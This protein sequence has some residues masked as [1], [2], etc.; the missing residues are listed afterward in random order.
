MSAGSRYEVLERIAVG[1]FASV[2]RARDRELGREV[3]IKQI[4]P[5]FLHDER[6]LARYWQE[7]QLLAGLQHPNI[8]TI[9][10]IVRS[11]GW[12]IVELM[13]G[14]LEQHTHGEPIDLE[15]LRQVLSS[16]LSALDFLHRN[17][18]I[19]GDIKP[20]NILINMQGQIKLG[21]FGLARRVTNDTGSLLKGTTKYMAPEFVSNQFG[22]VGPA[23]DIYSLG[24]SAFELM[25]GANQFEMLFPG[26][27]SFGRDKQIAW[28]MWHAAAD[29]HLPEI[30]RVLEGVP[31]DLAAVVQKMTY[32]EPS[33]RYPSAAH[34]LRDLR[35]DPMAAPP[36]VGP[37][38]DPAAIAAAAAEA[39]KK[40]R[41]RLA[42]IGALA[43]SMLLCLFL[44][45]PAAQPPP[46]TQG[47]EPIKGVVANVYPNELRL[48][49]R[50]RG[51]SG[52]SIKEIE[53]R[54]NDRV[55]INDKVQEF[56]ELKADDRVLIRPLL[57]DGR[58]ILELR[59]TRPVMHRG[60]V[61]EIKPDEGR[62]VLAVSEGEDQGKDLVIDVPPELQ[63]PLNGGKPENGGRIISL[64]DLHVDDR[65]SVDH[66]GYEAGRQATAI[67][68]QR[69]V[70]VEGKIAGVDVRQKVLEVA[71]AD[72]TSVLKLP[73]KPDCEVLINKQRLINDQLLKPTDLLPGDQV[74]LE[75]DVAVLRVN[76]YRILGEGGVVRR[77]SYPDRLVEVE[78]SDGGK[79]VS[80]QVGPNCEIT[81]GGESAALSDLRVGDQVDITH[82]TPGAAIPRAIRLSAVRPPDANRWAILIANQNYESTYLTRL[83]HPVSDA[84]AL[85]KVLVDRY[86]VPPQQCVTL[87]D[88]SLVRL[89]QALPD[90]LRHIGPE[91]SLLVYFAGHAYK[92]E[93]GKVF[94]APRS[95]DFTRMAST[96]LALQWLVDRIE[97]C[98][99]KTKLLF[100]DCGYPGNGNDLKAQPS[101]AEMLAALRAPPGR[102]PLRTITAVASAKAG[103]RGLI[104]PGKDGE[105]PQSLFARHLARAYLGEADK[106]LDNVLEPTELF[107]YLNEALPRSAR[108]LGGEQA[109]ELFLPDNRP[110]RLTDDAKKAIRRLA[111]LIRQDRFDRDL[112]AQ[113]FLEA[114]QAAGQEIEP[115]LIHAVLL[116]RGKQRD[117]ALKQ[118]EEIK[119]ERPG[120]ILP[121]MGIVWVHVEKRSWK[122]AVDNLIELIKQFPR[123]AKPGPKHSAEVLQAAEWAG[124]LREFIEKGS[125]VNDPRLPAALAALDALVQAQP[126]EVATAFEQGRSKTRGVLREFDGKIAAAEDNEALR[127][128]V[129]RKQIGHYS[130]FPYDDCVQ[131]VLDGLDS[132]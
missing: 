26:L 83:S 107:S 41:T 91:A 50:I 4:H 31:P 2:Y 93:E 116:L 85:A 1:D 64:V 3:A 53:L 106:N 123:S 12:L 128:R 51:E 32:K 67:T 5:Q 44:L 109:P 13:R 87:F 80:Y 47:E 49:V 61:K 33:R 25:V 24:F 34:A 10:D 108:E 58:K 62:F 38:E 127:L 45:W 69:V 7:A 65:V 60:V 118:C 22:P 113:A 52:D 8:M 43:V 79:T 75:H 103:Q 66:L 112:V 126:P 59:A 101:S 19:H 132:E 28:M 94:L 29:R 48:A 16:S 97:E 42:A 96:G 78:R 122:S 56:R 131:R 86:R 63:I 102:A 110:P 55:L 72:G 77:I 120:L 35:Y 95:F 90:R 88:E 84:Q 57:E 21:D 70:V 20:S 130:S 121:Q 82:D 99:A 98:Q 89:E 40:K 11:R 119:L 68:A 115:K 9:Y 124:G 54:R 125:D 37:S 81:L 100:L 27:S 14:N 111:A 114:S 23:S 71:V 76:A 73:F 15:L 105:P 6:Q 30:H 74:T 92:D 117:E 39:R 104:A 17:G 36:V 46:P 129:E 18:V